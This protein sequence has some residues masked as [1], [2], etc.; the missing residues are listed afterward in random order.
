M[1]QNYSNIVAGEDGCYKKLY[2]D[3][4]DAYRQFIADGAV[5]PEGTIN[6]TQNGEAIDVAQ[7]ASANVN[8]PTSG[9]NL[10]TL[11]VNSFD[12]TA[13]TIYGPEAPYDG[14][15]SVTV[16]AVAAFDDAYIQGENAGREAAGR[17]IVQEHNGDI[18]SSDGDMLAFTTPTTLE[19]T[20]NGDYHAEGH[21]YYNTVS[22]NVPTVQ[23]QNYYNDAHDYQDSPQSQ[24]VAPLISGPSDGYIFNQFIVALVNANDPTTIV[25]DA[26]VLDPTTQQPMGS[27]QFCSFVYDITTDY[28]VTATANTGYVII[29]TFA[30]YIRI[31]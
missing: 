10:T 20:E 17:A 1:S 26:Q 6:I 27:S 13:P 30:W 25:V 29:G 16:D 24:V 8:V 15:D 4:R 2:E 22:V 7:Y 31:D 18:V 19:V 23:T 9:G 28:T 14:F 12:S 11:Y 21:W 3:T 5:I